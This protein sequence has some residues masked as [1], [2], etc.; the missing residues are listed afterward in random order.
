MAYGVGGIT[1]LCLGKTVT[2]NVS[3]GTYPLSRITDGINRTDVYA[4]VGTGGSR[5]YAE[6]DLGGEYEIEKVRLWRYFGD[7]R[8]Y[9]QTALELIT[10]D[11]SYTQTLHNYITDGT[12]QEQ[13]N[14]IGRTFINPEYDK[15]IQLNARI[16]KG[17]FD[18][19]DM[20]GEAWATPVSLNG[21]IPYSDPDTGE[22]STVGYKKVN[23]I[24]YLRG[25]MK[26]GTWANT[27][28]GA[29]SAIFN[30]PVGYRPIK[31]QILSTYSDDNY[32]RVDVLPNGNVSAIA[33][34]APNGSL[35]SLSSIRFPA[36]Q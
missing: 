32:A 11:R 26:S 8:T 22:Y 2:S 10:S 19:C 15:G 25:L 12:Y 20:S 27:T 13:Q 3:G 30:L 6:I 1:N 5:A 24:V 35:C 7:G 34:Q 29:S 33:R 28:D 21:W 17:D 16:K 14:G 18:I 4:D 36:E 31:R 9:Y 23:G